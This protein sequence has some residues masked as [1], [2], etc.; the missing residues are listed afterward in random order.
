MH[1]LT[2][3]FDGIVSM[4]SMVAPQA[5]PINIPNIHPKALSSR[6]PVSILLMYF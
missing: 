4:F 5:S 3:A 6:E 2:S 1:M